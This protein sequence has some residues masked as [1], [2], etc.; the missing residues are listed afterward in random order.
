[1]NLEE[2]KLGTIIEYRR[3]LYVK[4]QGLDGN[5]MQAIDQCGH[6]MFV[7]DLTWKKFKIKYAN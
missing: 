6:W 5:I 2:L 4:V 7:K 3:R 1:M